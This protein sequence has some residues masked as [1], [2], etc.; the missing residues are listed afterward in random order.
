MIYAVMLVSDYTDPNTKQTPFIYCVGY[1]DDPHTADRYRELREEIGGPNDS[2]IYKIATFS[3][4]VF[5]RLLH[6]D[7]HFN[8]AEP[9]DICSPNGNI[10]MTSSDE[11]FCVDSLGGAVDQFIRNMDECVP[12]LKMFGDPEVK[13]FLKKYK[14]LRKRWKNGMDDEL[15]E[16]VKWVKAM[17]YFI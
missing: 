8:A 3:H 14:A 1:S 10:V 11:E 9:I 4:D 6:E 15:W 5:E 7:D 12:T 16:S 13:D 17:K 2:S